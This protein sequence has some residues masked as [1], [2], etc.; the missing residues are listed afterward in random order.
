MLSKGFWAFLL[1]TTT[2]AAPAPSMIDGAT[3]SIIHLKSNVS[4]SGMLLLIA[5]YHPL[6]SPFLDAFIRFQ[7]LNTPAAASVLPVI[8]LNKR[9]IG[10]TFPTSSFSFGGIHFILF[11]P[12]T[13]NYDNPNAPNG[14]STF[15]STGTNGIET[16]LVLSTVTVTVGLPPCS[17]SPIPNPGPAFSI[18][19]GQSSNQSSSI[20]PPT[21][22]FPSP[23]P[24]SA[25][26]SLFGVSIPAP[27]SSSIVQT[28]SATIINLSTPSASTSASGFSFS[29]APATSA[30]PPSFPVNAAAPVGCDLAC[31]LTATV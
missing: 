5:E 12:C 26:P 22:S 3:P 25:S 23:T 14:P 13:Y 10:S 7:P 6:E 30:T 24:S 31:L 2:I 11:H 21:I 1:I 20:L 16:V 8:K 15:T 17:S 27:V 29:S 18:P 28:S 4:C 19:S 9:Q